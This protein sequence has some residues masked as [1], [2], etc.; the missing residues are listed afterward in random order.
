[1]SLP[2]FRADLDALLQPYRF[3]RPPADPVP[4]NSL[5]STGVAG[6]DVTIGGGWRRGQVSEVVGASPFARM[7]VLTAT[8]AAATA[9]GELT[10]WIDTVD[11]G[12]P[13]SMAAAGVPLSHVVWVHGRPLSAGVLALRPRRG[14]PDLTQTAVQRA[15]HATELMAQA[16]RFGVV[17]LDL[18]DIPAFA[19]RAVPTSAWVRLHRAV[20]G[21]RTALVVLGAQPITH[22]ASGV[23]VRVQSRTR[24]EATPPAVV[25]LTHQPPRRRGVDAAVRIAMAG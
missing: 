11:R 24:G 22:S 8:L 9:R 5:L 10:A 17:V 3:D 21:R 13:A 7:R 20:E 2:R 4:A 12:E 15:L 18:G 1:M 25:P 6:L 19:L 16:G 14:D 23:S